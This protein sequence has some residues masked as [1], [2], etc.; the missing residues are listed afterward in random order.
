M[1]TDQDGQLCSLQISQVNLTRR[2][3]WSADTDTSILHHGPPAAVGENSLLLTREEWLWTVFIG[4]WTLH[5]LQWD[6]IHLMMKAPCSSSCSLSQEHRSPDVSSKLL[7]C[8]GLRWTTATAK[9]GTY[10]E[11]SFPLSHVSFLHTLRPLL[12]QQHLHECP[13]TNKISWHHFINSAFFLLIWSRLA[14]EVYK[15]L[16]S[17]LSLIQSSCEQGSGWLWFQSLC[18]C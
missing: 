5:R 1:K 3:L 7:V 17:S 16:V 14:T 8:P 2:P 10:Q 15:L 13:I 4:T 6:W 11:F 9:D 18:P 12:K